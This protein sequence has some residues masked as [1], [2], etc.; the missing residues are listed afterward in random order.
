MCVVL[1]FKFIY[2]R[3][4]LFIPSENKG[5]ER[6]IGNNGAELHGSDS[7]PIRRVGYRTEEI[8]TC[9]DGQF[10]STNREQRAD[11]S[12]HRGERQDSESDECHERNLR[13]YTV[14][15]HYSSHAHI[16]GSTYQQYIQLYRTIPY[17][18]SSIHAYIHA[19][20]P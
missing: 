16:I 1:S 11:Y 17:I 19:C 10:E 18:H 13:W 7:E 2:K 14:Y 20:I 15:I 8:R 4:L 6:K 3:F 9:G 5:V 12:H